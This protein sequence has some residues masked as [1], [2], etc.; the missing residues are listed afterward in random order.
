M[1]KKSIFFII[2]FLAACFNIK[3]TYAYSSKD[4]VNRQLCGAFEVAEAKADGTLTKLSCHDNFDLAKNAMNK[5]GRDNLVVLGGNPGNV[6]IFDATTALADFTT[7][8]GL[9]YLYND[10]QLKNEFSYITGAS[11]YGAT[12]G[13]FLET[14]YSSYANTFVYRVK[15]AG[16]DGWIKAG[17]IELV[18]LIWVKSTN[19]Y[20]VTDTTIRHNYTQKIQEVNNSSSGNT[21]G[22]KP[23]MLSPGTYISYDGH[24]FYKDLKTALKDYKVGNSHANSINKDEP[25]YNYYQYLPSHTR[26]SYSSININEYIRNNLGFKRDVFGTTA[27]TKDGLKSSR[28]YGSGTFFYNAQEVYGINAL[29]ALGISRNETGNG[30]SNLAI[31]KNN[32]F[33]LNAVDSSPTESANWYASFSSSILGFANK[34][35]TYGYSKPTDYRYF[36]SQVGSKF[37]GM[38]VK[39]ASDGFWSEKAASNYYSMDKALSLQ[40]YN[41][42]QLGITTGAIAARISPSTSAKVVYNYRGQ[43]NSVVIVDEVEGTS[44]N[45]STKWYKVVSDLNIDS[46][47]NEITSGPYN[48]NG[49]VYVPASY[50]MKI[51]K[52]VNG[53]ISP[54]NVTNYQDKDYTYDIYTE[55]VSMKLSPKVAVSTKETMYYYDP[56]LLSAKGQTL[57]KNRYVMVFATAYD[58]D[59]QPVSYLVTSD[60]KYDQKH[61]VKADTIKF[62]SSKYGQA[63]VTVSGQNTYTIINPTTVDS[64]STHIS[65]LYHY[66]YVPILEEKNVDGYLWY[67]VPVDLSGTNLEFGWTLASAPDVKINVYEYKSSNNPPTITAS[68]K[69]ILAG[70]DFDPK[71]DVSAYDNEDGDLTKEIKVIKN[72]VNNSIAGIYEVTYEVTDKDNVTV[73]KTIKVTVIKDEEPIINAHD[74][75]MRL[76]D[77]KPNLL[78][79]VSATDKEDGSITEI[80]VDDSKVIYTEPGT[81]PITYS[82]KDSF[83]HKVEKTI[84]LTVL[85]AEPPVINASDKTITIN[86]KFD[87]KA[88]VTATDYTGQDLTDSIKVTKNTV[89]IDT[90]GI[91]GVTYEVTDSN[92]K[93]TTKTIKVTV[94]DK[95]EKEGTFYFDYLNKV[96]NNLELRGYL[97]INGMNN[98]LMENISYKVIFTDTNDSSKTYEQ[99]A[100]R[101]TDLT[102]I[103]RPIFS[104]D[105]NTYTH[106]WFKANIDIDKL[107]IGNYT[108]EI[109]AE[110]DKYYSKALVNNKLYKTEITGFVGKEKSVNIKNNY[111]D[112]TS[113]VTL[114]VRNKD[115]SIKTVD[116]Y[117]NQYD[118]WRS[119]EFVDDKLHLMGATYSYGM[120]LAKDKEVTRKIIFENKDTYETYEYDLGSITNGL[121][122]VALPVSDN[123]DKTRAWYDATIDISNIPKGEYR[124]Y[125]T[126]T[127][128]LTDYS[129][130]T[131]NLGRSLSDK[132]ATIAGKNYQFN[133]NTKVGNIIELKVA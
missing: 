78:D 47:G 1:K 93:T 79:N 118:V 51:N 108:M 31:N 84:T 4:Y 28:L 60:Y 122:N 83:G 17:T 20:T 96:D 115:L 73:T 70:T 58:K 61:W 41:Y 106:A 64:L 18:P 127:A 25:Y 14:G 46:N 103:D 107:P 29:F 111:S 76:G 38:N 33:G 101:I 77:E 22:P 36:G 114:Y 74:I 6:K 56:S 8:S 39:Y 48:W 121:Y 88:G 105:G 113:A 102:G 80:T 131:D 69:E 130:F 35:A 71:K 19:T 24:Y 54:N 3:E 109:K 133:L 97:T 95:E 98:T 104:P 68:D 27:L 21:I 120:N 82:V 23:D 91:Y 132:K 128:N 49:Y 81:Y 10:I 2:L 34:W 112:R 30:T 55:P 99:A 125:I 66:N 87:E 100:T 94:S 7:Q 92:N 117:Y 12:D 75:Q 89:K 44:V 57:L 116:S 59:K 72:T 119:L 42:Y 26:T 50:I 63:S 90:V 123:L 11:A 15:V 67:R 129:E 85:E 37:S 43:E 52:G 5:D 65:G 40:D 16:F 32:G 110:S 45:G 126:T 86:S 62:T 53:Y 13:L 9:F 124:L